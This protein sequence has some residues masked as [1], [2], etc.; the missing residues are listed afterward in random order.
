MHP[1]KVFGY[2][3]KHFGE[4]LLRHRSMGTQRREDIGKVVSVVIIYQP[5]DIAG[6]GMKAGKIG[7][8]GEDFLSRTQLL[9]YLA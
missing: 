7:R 4:F 6:P 8:Q 3:A 5:G 9:K 1:E 2:I